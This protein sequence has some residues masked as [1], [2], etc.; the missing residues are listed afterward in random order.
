MVMT[1]YPKTAS[2]LSELA[3]CRMLLYFS[4]NNSRSRGDDVRAGVAVTYFLNLVN[5]HRL[6][7][8]AALVNFLFGLLGECHRKAYVMEISQHPEN[9]DVAK[10]EQKFCDLLT[11]STF[12]HPPVSAS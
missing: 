11:H 9:A 6:R 2:F 7:Y 5:A 8:C 12:Q 1:Y 4:E 10:I 3:S